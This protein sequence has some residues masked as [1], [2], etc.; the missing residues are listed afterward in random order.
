M[1]EIVKIRAVP[2]LLMA[3]DCEAGSAAPSW[4][5]KLRLAGVNARSGAAAWARFE[6]A[7]SKAANKETWP[8]DAA[9]L[10]IGFMGF[11]FAP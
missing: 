10:A 2:V 3:R 6:A 8:V 5:L 4:Y 9:R 1:M 11:R 7:S